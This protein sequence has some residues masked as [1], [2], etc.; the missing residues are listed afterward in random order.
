V[1]VSVLIRDVLP[2]DIA[3]LEDTI[4][5]ADRLE[6]RASGGLAPRQAAEQS[7]E[8]T[9]FP[10]SILFDG[11]LAIIYGVAQSSESLRVGIPW[12]LSTCI[13]P[14]YPKTF[15]KVTRAA[16]PGMFARHDILVNYVD[17]RYTSAV[18]WLKMLGFW[19]GDPT[20]FGISDEPFHP[21]MLKREDLRV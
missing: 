12:T 2:A 5:E 3:R 16:L 11:E 19:V 17:A 18:R 15:L 21:F 9:K 10:R 7:I 6:V 20:P 8:M 4:R 1:G 14:R 13:V